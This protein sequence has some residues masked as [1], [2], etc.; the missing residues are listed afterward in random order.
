MIYS[1]FIFSLYNE[2]HITR[3]VRHYIVY[4]AVRRTLYTI[5]CT[6]Y[7]EHYCTLY[8]VQCTLYSVQ[9]KLVESVSCNSVNETTIK[10][11]P[12]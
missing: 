1:I 7:N 10:H 2:Q 9:C 11:V 4:I 6:L 5:Q 12:T 8:S 3:L